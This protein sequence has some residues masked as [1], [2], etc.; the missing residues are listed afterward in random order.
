M[1]RVEIS[2]PFRRLLLFLPQSLSLLL[3]S[4]PL[5]HGQR[6]LQEAGN[7]S[8]TN[9]TSYSTSV[10]ATQ[11]GR[12]RWRHKGRICSVLPC[13]LSWPG[14][15]LSSLSWQVSET[16]VKQ[17]SFVGVGLSEIVLIIIQSISSQCWCSFSGAP[18]SS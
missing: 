10:G 5:L 8:T 13:L 9:E 2:P 18:A 15:A 4:S 3:L 6:Q 16:P 17:S 1:L 11:K 7:R 12:R 14:L